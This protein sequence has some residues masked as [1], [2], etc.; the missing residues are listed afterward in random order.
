MAI[1]VII[2]GSSFYDHTALRE[3]VVEKL[4]LIPNHTKLVVAPYEWGGIRKFRESFYAF[5][6][7]KAFI[8]SMIE[9]FNK[10]W[11]KL[12]LISMMQ[13]LCRMT[14]SPYDRLHKHYQFKRIR[15][16]TL[17]RFQKKQEEGSLA[18]V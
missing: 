8:T 10:R 4:A 9:I 12:D 7:D 18:S 14:F 16:S 3:C 17:P 5:S 11:Q 2:D 15:L 1:F 13:E 6:N